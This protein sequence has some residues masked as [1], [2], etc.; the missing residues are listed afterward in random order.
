M[1]NWVCNHLIIR[2][3]NAVEVM[4]SLLSENS[5]SENGYDVDFNK[6]IPMPEDLKIES[7]SVTRDCAKLYVNAMLEGCDAYKKYAALYVQAF[8]KDL[9]M[10]E[11]E[12]IKTMEYVM[13]HKDY[14]KNC[15]MFQ[16]KADAYAYGKKALDNYEKYGAKDWYD[17]SIQN[18]GTKWN[19]LDTI[20]NDPGEANVY[21]HTAWSAPLPF[22]DALSQKYPELTFDYE[23]ADEDIGYNTGKMTI[24]D[25]EILEGGFLEDASK[26]AYETYFALWG[27]EDEYR[28]NAKTG[29]YEYI[30]NEE[31]M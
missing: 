27:G 21:F 2:G 24:R 23:F 7:G 1:P 16:T 18:W 30:D 8:G 9:A 22:L 12:Q 13:L 3:N 15:P 10:S 14:E 31:A 11:D 4:N 19:A 17:W 29:T 26:E 6:I 28:F 25:G 5:E 20:V